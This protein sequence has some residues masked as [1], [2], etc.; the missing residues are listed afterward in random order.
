MSNVIDILCAIDTVDILNGY[1]NPSQDSTTPTQITANLIYMIV[2]QGSAISGN[3]QG[4]LNVAAN[5]GD[6]IRWRELT[7]SN[8]F[9]NSVQFYNFS[10]NTQDLI[11]LP[12]TLV[13]GVQADGTLSTVQEAMPKQSPSAPP[14][15]PTSVNNTPFHFWESTTESTGSVTY[16]WQFLIADGNGN[17]LGYFQW[18]PFITI[19][20]P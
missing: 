12:P 2:Q 13:G 18:D 17:V 3:G 9:E 10:V 16:H 14:W 15:L 5:I 19:S 7:L 20:E 6:V 1:P 11:T 4:E 8:N